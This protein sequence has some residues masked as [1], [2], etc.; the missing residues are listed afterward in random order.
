MSA[1]SAELLQYTKCRVVTVFLQAFSA[2]LSG[3]KLDLCTIL[4]SDNC[5]MCCLGGLAGQKCRHGQ[6]RAPRIATCIVVEQHMPPIELFFVFSGQ[7]PVVPLQQ[8]CEWLLLGFHVVTTIES[9]WTQ[10]LRSPGPSPRSGAAT[11]AF[12]AS[13]QMVQA[14]LEAREKSQRPSP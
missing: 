6:P 10:P 13:L 8:L 9:Q 4:Y 3:L 14:V 5:R 2:L 7:I 1:P 11:R 12:D